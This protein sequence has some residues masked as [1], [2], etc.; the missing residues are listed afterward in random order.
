MHRD[1]ADPQMTFWENET[2]ARLNSLTVADKRI[3]PGLL[4]KKK[5]VTISR[6]RSG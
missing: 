4:R 3:G 1:E 2:L 5:I 6:K